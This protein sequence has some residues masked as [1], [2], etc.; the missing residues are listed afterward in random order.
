MNRMGFV[1]LACAALTCGATSTWAAAPDPTVVTLKNGLRVLLAPDSTAFAAEV[2]V[3]YPAGTRWESAGLSG[4][5][6]LSTRLMFR[7]SAKVPDGAHL[8]QL[9]AE[10]AV[11]NSTNTS[12]GT[13]LWQT[14][15][16]EAVPLALRLEADRMSGLTTS[17]AAFEAARADARADR[18]ARAEASPIARGLTRL[19]ATAF[20]GGGYG[21]P[22]YGEDADLQ[23]M[24]PR[25]VDAWRRSHYAAG[26]AVLVLAGRFDPE[27]T[28]AYVRS[29]FEGLPRGA[30]PTA[31]RESAAPTTE[32]RG[33]ARGS[34]P[35]RL[36]FAGWRGPGATDADAPAIELMAA[37]LGADGSQF[38]GALIGEWKVAVVTQARVEIHRDASLLWVTAA[39]PADADSSTA[40]RVM[41][42]EVGRLAREPVA[43][44]VLERARARLLTDAAFSGQTVHARA[45]TLGEACF[46]S[47]DPAAAKRRLAAIEAV[48]AA[49]LQRVAK[50]VVTDASRTVYWY[51]PSG[52]G[53]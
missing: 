13:C 19:V 30:A 29:L 51:V 36:A 6:H 17:P 33:W 4:A 3:W 7:G 15:P 10:G 43:A 44:E 28:L 2:A 34:T 8:S 26:S 39:L 12:D 1:A 21:R 18:R 25:D 23:R 47:G 38:Q 16:A 53:R 45:L 48:T 20:P 5:S 11:V 24:T 40:E 42:D 41:L 37:V 32:R 22:L 14:V 50:R 35:L 49:D 52:E 31:P 9:Q 46:E 27:P